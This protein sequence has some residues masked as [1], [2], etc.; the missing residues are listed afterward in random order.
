MSLLQTILEA[1]GGAAVNQLARQ[2]GLNSNQANSALSQLIP[3]LAGGLKQNVSQGGLDSLVSA[4]QKGN[5]G[6]Y[7]DRPDQLANQ[8]TQQDGNAILGHIF[9][10]KEVSRQVASHA[11]GNTGLDTGVLKKMLPIVATMVM[12]GLNKQSSSGGT[13]SALLGGGS[14]SQSSVMGNML[15]SFLDADNDGNIVDDLM[16]KLLR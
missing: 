8:S 14:S 4:L 12:G 13:L 15:T 2:F 1:Q 7:L 5:H 3:A 6:Q 10:S 11:A 9:G 16:S